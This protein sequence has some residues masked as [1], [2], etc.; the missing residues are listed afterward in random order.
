MKKIKVGVAGA[1][2]MGSGIAQVAA[3][4]GH[5]VV[6]MD[7][8]QQVLDKAVA[9][10]AASTAKLVEKNRMD[11]VN[12]AQLL[13]RIKTAVSVAEFSGCGL[14][15]EAV[16][17]KL[18]IKQDLFRTIEKHIDSGAI[19]ATNTSSLPVVSIGSGCTHS[20]RVIGI[21][22]FNPAV[23]MPLVEIVPA[24]TTDSNVIADAQQL[25]GSWGKHAVVVKDTPGFIVNR[26]ARPFYGEA[27]KMY[28]EGIASTATIDWAM[29]ELGGFRMGP[30]EL[31]DF[32]GNDVNFSVTETVW[33]QFFYDPRYKPSLT[34]QRLSEAGMFGR[35]SG[36]GYYNYASGAVIPEPDRNQALGK[37]IFERILAML[38]NEAAD[39]LYLN[40]ASRDDIDTAMTKGV[41]YPMGLL[42]WADTFGI[43]KVIEILDGLDAD[44]RDG[45]YRTSLLLRKMNSEVRSFY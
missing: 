23:L 24:I 17:E 38:I 35:K 34:Q 5:D 3:A 31:M 10:I 18:E 14:V 40:I 16:V 12:A 22:F 8:S 28:E 7:T 1:G 42:K 20:N 6:L 9:S 27:I 26:V 30:F 36:Q 4:A 32:I 33:K 11:A 45:R 41:N 15:I 21:H 37:Y 44:Y 29:R 39:A 13:S 25:I 43:G 19:L 2:S